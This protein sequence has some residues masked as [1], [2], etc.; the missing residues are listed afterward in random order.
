MGQTQSNRDVG[1]TAVTHW[2]LPGGPEVK[3]LLPI[4]G[5]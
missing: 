5:A 4:Q 3:T 1:I 2:G